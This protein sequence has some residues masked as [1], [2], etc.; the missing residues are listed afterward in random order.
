MINLAN[1][2]PLI[3]GQRA[4]AFTDD[5]SFGPLIVDPH[6]TFNATI[7]FDVSSWQAHA[8][9]I[10]TENALVPTSD[11]QFSSL[12]YSSSVYLPLVLREVAHE[13]GH[14]L[15]GNHAQAPQTMSLQQLEDDPE[16]NDGAQA[17]GDA[18]ANDGDSAVIA[19]P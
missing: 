4:D 9:S 1:G 3:N 13:F 12:S 17:F 5:G 8:A 19:S 10:A 2:I 11:S 7:T 6:Q 18:G 14:L 16:Y 15:S